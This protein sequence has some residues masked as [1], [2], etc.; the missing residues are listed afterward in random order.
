MQHII[1]DLL[2]LRSEFAIFSS[3]AIVPIRPR[4]VNISNELLRC[5]SH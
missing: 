4:K 3:A 5:G 1:L 2:N